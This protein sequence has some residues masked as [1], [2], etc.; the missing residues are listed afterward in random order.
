[1]DVYESKVWVG[2]VVWLLFESGVWDVFQLFNLNI[3]LCF[4]LTRKMVP[5]IQNHSFPKHEIQK[6]EF[7]TKIILF[8]N[9]FKP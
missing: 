8:C 7:K 9:E 1:M 4:Y 2:G 3:K 5:G 6:F